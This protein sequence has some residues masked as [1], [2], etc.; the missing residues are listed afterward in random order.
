VKAY[1]SSRDDGRAAVVHLLVGTK[2]R[3]ADAEEG[4][5]N[6]ARW[7]GASHDA[8]AEYVLGKN[9]ANR[10]FWA[11]AS[12]RLSAALLAGVPTPHIEREALRQ[13][14]FA[15][16]ALG[17]LDAA[18]EI[19]DRVVSSGGPFAESLGRREWLVGFL[20]RCLAR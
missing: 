7:A 18:R 16:C 3:P 12:A 20:G 8:V 13:R 19:R 10:E 11:E 9:L 6:V 5:A 15:A 17:D 2:G 4:L 1:A 14:A